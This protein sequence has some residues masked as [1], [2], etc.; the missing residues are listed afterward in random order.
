MRAEELN[1]V[2]GSLGS[3][4]VLKWPPGPS[5]PDSRRFLCTP[6]FLRVGGLLLALPPDF[7]E[8]L[9]A[10]AIAAVTSPLLGPYQL[11]SVPA[12]EEDDS[13]EET[14]VGMDLPV[15]L[16]DLDEGILASMSLH[17]PV[18]DV[19]SLETFMAE[20]P[21][22]FPPLAL[23]FLRRPLPC[24]S[25][26]P[27]KSLSTP[28]HLLQPKRRLVTTAQLAGQV[29]ALACSP[30]SCREGAS[31]D[32]GC[33]PGS[34]SLPCLAQG[35]P[36]PGRTAVGQKDLPLQH[37]PVSPSLPEPSGTQESVLVRAVTQQGSPQHAG[38][39]SSGSGGYFGPR[40]G[41]FDIYKCP[42]LYE[43]GKAS[44]GIGSAQL[45]FLPAY[46]S[47]RSSQD[48][49]CH[50]RAKHFGRSSQ[51]GSPLNGL[52]RGTFRRVCPAKGAWLG[53]G[54]PG[55]RRGRLGPRRCEG[56]TRALSACHD[57]RR[58]G[59]FRRGKMGPRFPSLVD[60]GALS[61]AVPAKASN[62]QLE[63]SAF[64]PASSR[65]F[66][67]CHL[68]LCKGNRSAGPAEERCSKPW[69]RHQGGSRE[70]R[71]KGPAK[72]KV[73][74]PPEAEVPGSRVKALQ[75][76][77]FLGGCEATVQLPSRSSALQEPA[78]VAL[79]SGPSANEPSLPSSVQPPLA[80][81]N[82]LRS[83]SSPTFRSF[84]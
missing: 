78:C 12:A 41:L 52:L 8:V 22:L 66:G 3:P 13:G 21:H 4:C 19:G 65:K 60:S 23:G 69:P 77:D 81:R 2:E 61:H 14:L 28:R 84:R 9:E 43:E 33:S 18:T 51:S 75:G 59:S 58:A 24:P 7:V 1:I 37:M 40:G 10:N 54:P 74:L 79:G 55:L 27:R 15:V 76:A 11:A 67:V 73:S 53:L 5:A 36:P 50:P 31:A 57:E 42:G 26:L 62:S 68:S 29:S 46:A 34:P 6:V 32:C 35:L 48:V 72:E 20:L 16:V 63:S 82:A 83:R 47:E 71:S 17:D 38:F 30:G 49:P 25:C 70:S 39:A 56:S 44:A 80:N 64:L 45:H